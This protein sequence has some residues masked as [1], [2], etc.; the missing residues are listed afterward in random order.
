[1]VSNIL[2]LLAIVLPTVNLYFI[3]Y[4]DQYFFN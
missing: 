4:I 1:M 2:L 3:K